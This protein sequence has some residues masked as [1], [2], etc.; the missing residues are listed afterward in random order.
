M[1]ISIDGIQP[2]KGHET[3][4]VI[5][6]NITGTVLVARNLQNSKSENIAKLLLE[7]KDLGI[8]VLGIVSDGQQSLKLAISKVFPGVPHQLCHY[9][10]LR[11]IAFKLTEKDRKMK[12]EIKKKLRG[13]TAVE[14]RLGRRAEN[15]Q[16]VIHGYLQAIRS[17]LLFKGQ[18]PLNPPGIMIFEY[19]QEIKVSVEEALLHKE[20]VDL[21][22]LL[23]I[24]RKCDEYI[25]EYESLKVA[26]GWILDISRILDPENYQAFPTDEALERAQDDLQNFIRELK[27][28]KKEH[29]EHKELIT[30]IDKMTKSYWD[31]LFACFMSQYIPRT[32]NDLE[33]FFRALKTNHRRITGR[34][35][36]QDF[37]LRIGEY[38]VFDLEQEVETIRDRIKTVTW[39]ELSENKGIWDHKL[40]KSRMQ[41]RFKRDPKAY[42]KDLN[43]RWK[44]L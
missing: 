5:R 16:E 11:N 17:V 6:E 10:Y 26:K 36:W 7:I 34:V 29:P 1:V 42:L 27:K 12:T 25:P 8:K 44:K 4:Y 14:E 35:S 33:R 31:G 41:A 13:M 37:I 9:H 40:E 39:E 43:D 15:E 19:L 23:K 20:D 2:E 24:A 22:R 38:A 21:K 28:S 18:A 32:N 3:L 30:D